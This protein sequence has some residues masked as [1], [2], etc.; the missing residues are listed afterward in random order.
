M[1]ASLFE[2]VCCMGDYEN[3]GGAINPT[4][5]G[6]ALTLYAAGTVDASFVADN[7]MDPSEGALTV[8]QETDLTSLLATM[9][10][11]LLSFLSAFQKAQW[12]GKVESIFWAARDGR[13]GFTT[14]ALVKT[15]LGV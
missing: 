10:A 4:Y 7:C 5:I 15:A 11:N 13:T 6:R 1:T 2:R 9:P 14:E 8:A 12:A 3:D